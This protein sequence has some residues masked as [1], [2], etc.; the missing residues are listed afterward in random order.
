MNRKEAEELEDRLLREV[1]RR[2]NLG[3]YSP[4]SPAMLMFAE[5]LYEIVR[6]LK[7]RLPAPKTKPEKN[8]DD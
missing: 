3:G 7:E 4:D 2:R 1:A 5:T 6:H 8:K